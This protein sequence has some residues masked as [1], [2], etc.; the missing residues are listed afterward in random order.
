LAQNSKDYLKD[1]S[2]PLPPLPEQRR[3]AEIL[4]TADAAIRE[5]ER[6][7]AKLR[8]VKQG[9]LHDLLTRGLDAHGHLR[10]PAVH[11]EQFKDSP[12]GRIP[13]GWETT[14]VDQVA[15]TFAGGTPSRSNAEYY[16]GDI[17]WVKSSEI[18]KREINRTEET[19]TQS[20]YQSSSAKW[21]PVETPLI[22]M[23]GATAGAVSWLRIKA[24]TNQAVLAVLPQS[25]TNARWLYWELTFRSNQILARVQGSGQPNLSKTLI[26]NSLVHLLSTWEQHRIATVLD[27]HDTRI[28]AEE[29]VL[30]KRRQ[31]KRGLMDDLLT[32]RVRV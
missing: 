11:P 21:V 24:V 4:D 27:A 2:I 7:I 32:G 18:N 28:R 19:L 23:Y 25:D 17:P 30:A 14:S 26:D 9:L 31:V 12:L 3:I 29:T 16:G 15:E 20:G 5:T 1:L 6:V 13:R 8:Q 10:D 22:A